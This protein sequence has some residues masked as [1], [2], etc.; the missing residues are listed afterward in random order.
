M[1]PDTVV[2]KLKNFANQGI[3]IRLPDKIFKPFQ[4]PV[5]LETEYD[6]VAYKIKAKTSDPAIEVREHYLRLAFKT[7]LQVQPQGED[8]T[9]LRQ[10]Y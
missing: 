1:N 3:Q 8:K 10:N 7:E 2:A 6:A 9:I 4:L 5:T